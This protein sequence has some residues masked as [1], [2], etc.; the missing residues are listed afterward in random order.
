VGA[1]SSSLTVSVRYAVPCILVAFLG[2]W[3]LRVQRLRTT[4]RADVP[5]R[6]L[7]AG[8][9]PGTAEPDAFPG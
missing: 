8:A 7:A 2:S 9:A 4:S 6:E 1:F 5:A 3:L